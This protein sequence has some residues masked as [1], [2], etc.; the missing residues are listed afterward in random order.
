[1]K[2]LLVVVA[3]L[4]P[5]FVSCGDDDAA[6]AAPSKQ[7]TVLAASSLTDA[8]TELGAAFEEANG[9]DV[10]FSFAGSAALVE[11]AN[12]GAPADVIVTADQAT[13]DKAADVSGP[14]V[15][16]RNRIAIVVEKGNP[17]GISGL[18]DLGRDDLIVVLCAPQV[19][20]GKLGAKAL[21]K[22]AVDAHPKSL[23]ENVKGVV[24]KVTLGE[25]DAGIVYVTDIRAAAGKA[26]GVD[27]DIAGEPELEA[28]YPMGVLV[29][30]AH[31]AEAQ[32]WLEFVAGP[33]GQRIMSEHGFLSP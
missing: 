19:P 16:G 30:T 33:E 11:Q 24:S 7:I 5:L 27:I 32:E 26:D 15:I 2:K 13:Y 29:D 14:T 25:A 6:P 22:V 17:K 21:E 18:Q 31:L 23:E 10:T 1:M 12:S 20:C 28:V 3:V 9:V 4:L 8:F